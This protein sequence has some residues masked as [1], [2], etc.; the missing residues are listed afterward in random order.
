[1][2]QDQRENRSKIFEELEKVEFSVNNSKNI[3]VNNGLRKHE[4]L[5]DYKPEIRPSNTSIKKPTTYNLK[6]DESS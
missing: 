2:V 3:I 4:E 1:M 6:E 5:R